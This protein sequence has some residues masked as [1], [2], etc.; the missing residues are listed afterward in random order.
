MLMI[1]MSTGCESSMANDEPDLSDTISSGH[2]DEDSIGGLEDTIEPLTEY[3]RPALTK[4]KNGS[5]KE[6]MIKKA[7]KKFI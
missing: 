5:V 6:S 4:G 3:L 2:I 1:V 7:E